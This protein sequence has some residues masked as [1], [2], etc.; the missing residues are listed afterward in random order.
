M[1]A[2]SMDSKLLIEDNGAEN[3]FGDGDFMLRVG[4]GEIIRGQG[5]IVT[6]EEIQSL[7]SLSA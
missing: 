3:L 7:V 2:S 4:F 1:T 6:D 5:A